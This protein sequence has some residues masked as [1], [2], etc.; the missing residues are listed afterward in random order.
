VKGV[1][2]KTNGRDFGIYRRGS[3]KRLREDLLHLKRN[4][5]PFI[6]LG[7]LKVDAQCVEIRKT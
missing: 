6:L 1:S 3:S 7:K 2:V 5:E 4:V